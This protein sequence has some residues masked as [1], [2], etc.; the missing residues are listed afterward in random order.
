M[1]LEARRRRSVEQT[2][3]D[4]NGILAVRHEDSLLEMNPLPPIL[5]HGEAR[6][7]TR[8]LDQCGGI[9]IESTPRAL[10]AV[11]ESRAAVQH[12]PLAE[13]IEHHDAPQRIRRRR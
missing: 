5:P 12:E 1:E 10:F 4:V 3:C 6:L 9:R 2:I 13:V 8:I 11:E 7:E